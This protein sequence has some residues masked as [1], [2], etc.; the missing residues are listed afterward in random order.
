VIAIVL[1]TRPEIVK[2]SPIVRACER[3][4][5]DYYILHTGQHYSYEMDRAFFDTL[6][7]PEPRYNLEVGSG[8]HSAQ[9][10]KIMA[11]IE[12][13][14]I[15]DRPDVV[16]VQGDTNTVL[17]GALAASKLQIRVG[18][19][20]AGLRSYDR[21]MPE[22]INRVGADHISDYLFTPT[23]LGRLTLVSEGIDVEKVFVTGN[24]VVDAVFQ[25]LAIAEKTGDALDRYGLAHREYVL[26]TVHRAE[27]VDS[28]AR[29]ASILEALERVGAEFGQEVV[30]PIHPRTEK[31]IAAFGLSTRSIRLVPPLDYLEFLQLEKHASLI[32]TDSGGLQEEACILRVPCVTLRENT[33]R[34]S[35]LHVGGNVLAGTDTQR[36]VRASRAMFTRR[37][38]WPNPY[39]DGRSGEAIIDV[40]VDEGAVTVPRP[41]AAGS[42]VHDEIAHEQ[43]I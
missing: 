6:E 12:E 17:G 9:T 29:L 8:N 14:L 18:H 4:G 40:L 1:G 11:G 23:E 27:N 30:F 32:L 37:R 16:L 35:T 34:P 39:G 38:E 26:A 28:H 10:G 7:L 20:E 2:M 5:L 15:Q 36:I 42:V 33:E 25:N 21:S 43:P 24:T 13:L 19:V 22:D 41:V 31:M 3:R